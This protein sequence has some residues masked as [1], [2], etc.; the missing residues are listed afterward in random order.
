MQGKCATKFLD[1]KL[2]DANIA[3]FQGTNLQACKLQD[4]T[5]LSCKLQDRNIAKLQVAR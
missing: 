4:V 3:K 1:C 2:Q 5:L